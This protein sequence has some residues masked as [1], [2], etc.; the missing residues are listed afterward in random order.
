MTRYNAECCEIDGVC[1]GDLSDRWCCEG[2][3]YCTTTDPKMAK[4]D[5][6]KIC[7]YIPLEPYNK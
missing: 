6:G 1:V 7:P 5:K 4:R 2:K 3:F